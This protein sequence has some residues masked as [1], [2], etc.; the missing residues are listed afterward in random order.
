MLGVTVF[1]LHKTTN[2]A[3]FLDTC[4]ISSGNHLMKH[5]RAFGDAGSSL[6]ASTMDR[7]GGEIY[8]VT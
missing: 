6:D 2:M 4:Y 3:R 1:V 5:K 7:M 8:D